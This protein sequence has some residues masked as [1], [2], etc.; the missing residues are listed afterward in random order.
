MKIRPVGAQ[1]FYAD[2][3]T[4]GHAEANSCYEQ[5]FERA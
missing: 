2:G 5:L 4:D 1:L 3:R